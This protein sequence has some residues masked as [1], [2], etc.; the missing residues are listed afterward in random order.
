MALD[1]LGFGNRCAQTNGEIVGEMIA[2]DGYRTSVAHHAAA[3][4]DDLGGTAT[5]IEQA[6]TEIALVLRETRFGGGKRLEHGIADQDS[7]AICGGDQILRG[8]NRRSD[9]MNVG[10]EALADPA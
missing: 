10:F 5:D 4:D 7:G 1:A 9:E 6:A 8:G 3:V 2:A